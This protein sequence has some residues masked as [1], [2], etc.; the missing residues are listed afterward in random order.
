MLLCMFVSF[1]YGNVQAHTTVE[2]MIRWI[3]C[4]HHPAS[5]SILSG[6]M[7][8]AMKTTLNGCHHLSCL[9]FL[10]KIPFENDRT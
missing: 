5:S 4:T 10:G 9:L 1:Y 3:S 7:I 2:Q 6:E 8:T